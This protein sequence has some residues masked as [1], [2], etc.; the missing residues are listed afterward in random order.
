MVYWSPPGA[1]TPELPNYTNAVIED[2]KFVS[3]A[4]NPD[5]ERG[6]HKARVFDEMGYRASP[7]LVTLY[8]PE[9]SLL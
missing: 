7:R 2:E 3:Y 4:L 9:G 1:R 6:Q 8:I 5:S